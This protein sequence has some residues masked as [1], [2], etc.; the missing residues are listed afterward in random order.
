M[1]KYNQKSNLLLDVT[2]LIAILLPIIQLSFVYLPSSLKG[3]Y[4]QQDLFLGVSLVTLIM[5]YIVI[6]A[7]KSK[8]YFVI[9]SPFHKKKM[10][11]YN[12]W[13]QGRYEASTAIKS[14]GSENPSAK[15]IKIFLESLNGKPLQ[16]PFQIDSENRLSILISLLMINALMFLVVGLQGSTGWLLTLQSI[17]YFFIIIFSVLVLVI[18]RDTTNNS[19]RYEDE[20]RHNT[21]RAIELAILN[22]CFIPQPQIKFISTYGGSGLE[23]NFVRV[24]F[25][26]DDYEIC[27]NPAATKLI[28]CY[29]LDK[30]KSQSSV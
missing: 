7:Y 28:Y 19:R 12:D 4:L 26:E 27:T 10:N 8:P 5:S 25:H 1:E 18:Y 20:L 17:N 11:V 14:V 21:T 16:R 29:K 22:N 13:Q 23:N 9:S 30:I 2:S 24:Q 6:V 15:K 3:I